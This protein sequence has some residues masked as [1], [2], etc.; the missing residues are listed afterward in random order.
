VFTLGT[1]AIVLVFGVIGYILAAP[2]R[3]QTVDVP[4]ESGL[5]PA[6]GD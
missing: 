1:L 2:V 6:A 4:L 3:A 5:E